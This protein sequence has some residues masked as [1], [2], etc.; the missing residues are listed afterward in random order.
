MCAFAES[1]MRVVGM[2]VAFGRIDMI[3][4]DRGEM[5]LLELEL[6]QPRLFLSSSAEA[7]DVLVRGICSAIEKAK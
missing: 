2:P 3:P 5:H 4:G 1:A 7:L 6:L